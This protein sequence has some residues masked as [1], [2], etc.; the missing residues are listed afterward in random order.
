MILGLPL[1]CT[2]TLLP[3]NIEQDGKAHVLMYASLAP[4]RAKISRITEMSPLQISS[5]RADLR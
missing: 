5:I 1:A 4:V 3:S 2:S